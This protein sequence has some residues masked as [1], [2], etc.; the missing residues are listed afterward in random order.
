V[1]A[2]ENTG[3]AEI[4]VVATCDM[5][6]V[7]REMFEALVEA[8]VRDPSLMGAMMRHRDFVEPFPIALRVGVLESLRERLAHAERSVRA[9]VDLPSFSCIDGPNDDALWTN[10]NHPDE[11]ERFI[12]EA[13]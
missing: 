9:L 8:L 6:L 11:F 7:T 13:C 10:L 4:I 1:T 3:D 5:P 2:L 12:A